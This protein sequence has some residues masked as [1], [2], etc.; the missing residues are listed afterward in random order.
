V[1]TF[2]T[3]SHARV[4]MVWQLYVAAGVMVA[5]LRLLCYLTNS[6]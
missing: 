3:I 4:M 2:F 1:G 6:M 5:V